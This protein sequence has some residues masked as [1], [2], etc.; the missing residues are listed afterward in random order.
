M[1]VEEVLAET[2]GIRKI[3]GVLSGETSRAEAFP[4]LLGRL[5][6]AVLG[7]VSERIGTERLS[8]FLDRHPVRNQFR[9]R[10]EIDAVEAGPL[11][12]RGG[13]TPPPM[14]DVYW[15]NPAVKALPHCP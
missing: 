3:D 4:G 9:A 7:N 11:D 6:H 12:R 10:S 14:A 8:D 15:L 5:D 2:I 13:E 1:D